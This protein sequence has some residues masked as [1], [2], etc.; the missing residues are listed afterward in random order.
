MNEGKWWDVSW[1]PITGCTSVSAGCDRCWARRMARR[2][3]DDFRPKF[4]SKRLRL[5]PPRTGESRKVFV[6]SMGD[7]FHEDIPD[8]YIERIWALMIGISYT[9]E[10]FILTKRPKRM[11]QFLKSSQLQN[12]AN[13]IRLGVSVEDQKTAN[14]RIARLFSIDSFKKFVSIEP[15]LGPVDLRGIQHNGIA[16]SA[17]EK[18]ILMPQKLYWVILGGET[19][20]GAR[21]LCP[22][23]AR[24][25]RD[26]C[27]HAKVPFWFKSWGK[28]GGRSIDGRTWD[29]RPIC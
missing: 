26:Q 2:F 5:P 25:V 10:F 23:W 1:N 17:L 29:Q 15:M 20:P 28:E 21:P 13:H 8:R 7:L 11:A 4:H 12:Y 24:S 9:H 14:E 19:G 18:G 22:D 16:F 27:V 3:G 6:C